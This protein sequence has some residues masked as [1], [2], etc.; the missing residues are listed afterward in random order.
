MSI[1]K[2]TWDLDGH[3]DLTNS[4]LNGYVGLNELFIWGINGQGALGQ[5]DITHRSSPVQVPGTQWDYGEGKFC[6]GDYNTFAI[7]TDGTLWSWGYNTNGTLGQNNET[8]Y[9][10]PVQIPGTQ[11]SAISF[12]SV[13]GPVLALKS[14]GTL[15]SWG[16]GVYGSGGYNESFPK[17]SSPVQIPGTQ[18]SKISSSPR[19]PLA[20]KSDGTL[21]SWGENGYGQGGFNNAGIY[22]SS[23]RQIPGTQWEHLGSGYLANYAIKTDGTLWSWG[24][25]SG[26][27]LGHNNT[28]VQYSSP[29]QIPGTQWSSISPSQSSSALATKTDGTLWAWGVGTN[30]QLGNNNLA[31]RSSPIQ[32]PGTQWSKV[33]SGSYGGTALKTDNTL[34]GWGQNNY[35]QLA[36]NNRTQYSS[37]VQVPGTPWTNI[38]N[39]RY[40][41]IAFKQA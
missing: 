1:R 24:N 26:G 30:G 37:P 32:V 5:N 20:L 9:S 29:R 10:S 17:R 18:W 34:W 14:D 6:V 3:Y 38:E 13:S 16:Y 41:G 7:K 27:K 4:G 22:Y 36:Q 11:W 12:D 31:D 8:R 33:A 15:W 2:N 23:P 25:N 40:I 39:S 21:W 35:G 28:A 19:N